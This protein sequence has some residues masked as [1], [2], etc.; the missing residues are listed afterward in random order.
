MKVVRK[1]PESRRTLTLPFAALEIL[2]ELRDSTPKSVYIQSLLEKEKSRRM[3][4]AFYREAVA[5]Y[6]PDVCLEA[7]RVNEEVPV[8][9]DQ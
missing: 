2:D 8:A 9:E 1:S 6:T 4:R 3:R 7:L 5:A